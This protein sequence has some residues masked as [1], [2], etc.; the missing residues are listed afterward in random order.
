MD[1]LFNQNKFYSAFGTETETAGYRLL[2]AGIGTDVISKTKTVLSFYISATN[3]TDVAYQ[4][5]LSR[6]K[7]TAE[8]NVTGRAGVYNMGRN[9][10]LKLIVP[11]DFIK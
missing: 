2:N 9:I 8:N 10:S 6:L 3:L 11:L 1:N 4:S 7:Y 5:H